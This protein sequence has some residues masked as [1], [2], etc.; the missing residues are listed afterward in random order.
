MDDDT[1]DQLDDNFA[2]GKQDDEFFNEVD[3]VDNMFTTN[4]NNRLLGIF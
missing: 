3:F 2:N 4:C 1:L